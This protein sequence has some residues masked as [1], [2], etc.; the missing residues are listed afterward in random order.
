MNKLFYL[1]VLSLF[2]LDFFYHSLGVIPRV[3]TWLQEI[4]A[5]VVMMFAILTFAI[6]KSLN[7]DRK[8]LVA[9]GFFLMVIVAG[10]ILNGVGPG[11]IFIGIRAYFKHLPLFFL[12]LVYNFSEKEFK[13][14]LNF[15]LPLLLLQCPLSIFQRFIQ[16]RGVPTGDVITGTLWL[17]GLLSITMIS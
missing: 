13:N 1:I 3:L 9:I 11:A 14:Q 16:F 8:Y 5:M 4:L 6:K 2:F 10:V 17:S 15:I 7:V 12:P